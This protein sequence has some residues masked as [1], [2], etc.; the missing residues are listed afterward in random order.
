MRSQRVALAALVAAT[1]GGCSND[2]AKNADLQNEANY[3]DT[4]VAP[5]APGSDVSHTNLPDANY[6]NADLLAARKRGLAQES[7]EDAAPEKIGTIDP[8]ALDRYTRSEYPDVVA[9][10]GKLLPT[11]ER[12]RR[13]AAE[14]AAADP[15]CDGVDNAQVTDHG[16]RT[17]RHYMIEC[18]NISRLYFSTTSLT[19]HKAA[20]VRTGADIG[21]QGVLDY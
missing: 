2:A 13:E 20:M 11:V 18:N 8:L 12:E 9:R 17:D 7:A 21:A 3:Q 1:L 10:W 16:S 14:L 6:R 4:L 5:R 15:R 19:R